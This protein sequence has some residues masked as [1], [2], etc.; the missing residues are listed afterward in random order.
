MYVYKIFLQTLNFASESSG[1][2]TFWILPNLCDFLQQ[3]LHLS[4]KH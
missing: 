3:D 1:P 2:P 4:L